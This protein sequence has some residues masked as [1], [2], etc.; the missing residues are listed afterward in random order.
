[1]NPTPN[2]NC[3]CGG[4]FTEQNRSIH[5]KTNLH[6]NYLLNK[7]GLIEEEPKSIYYEKCSGRKQYRINR[8]KCPCGGEYTLTHKARHMR[9]KIHNNYLNNVE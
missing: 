9:T 1:M 8:E 6:R 2:S 5:C 7:F 4:R 3:P